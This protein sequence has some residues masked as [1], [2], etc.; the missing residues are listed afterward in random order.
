MSKEKL[1]VMV[2][3]GNAEPGPAMG[4]KLGPLGVNI[5]QIIGKINQKTKKYEGMEVPVNIIVDTET[6]EF[7]IEVGTPSTSQLI[8]QKAKAEGGRTSQIEEGEEL[9][10][11]VGELN[12]EDVVEIAKEKKKQSFSKDLKKVVKEVIGTCQSMG[13]KIEDKTPKEVTEE[14][15]QGKHEEIF[16]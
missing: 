12:L 5:G 2:E 13:M 11:W 3:A 10:K 1:S 7:E 9:E 6:K 15:K 16:N 8:L 14:I 4:T